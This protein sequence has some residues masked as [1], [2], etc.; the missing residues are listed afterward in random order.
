[1]PN[2]G[3]PPNPPPG[4]SQGDDKMFT[5]AQLNDIVTKRLT[6]DRKRRSAENL[7]DEER[8]GLLNKIEGLETA[9]TAL[10][11]ELTTVKT[12]LDTEKKISEKAH[13]AFKAELVNRAIGESASKAGAVDNSVVFQLLE[14]RTRVREVTEDG[15]PTGK[16][17]T[18]VKV[19]QLVD[20]KEQS[21]WVTPDEGVKSLLEKSPFLVKSQTPAGAG[22]PP[23][24]QPPAKPPG[25]L[26]TGVVKS[27]LPNVGH[28]PKGGG[29]SGSVSDAFS[30]AG[31][32]F[33]QRL[34]QS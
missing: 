4:G 13:R 10:K 21:N 9:N 32:L 19:S 8:T 27:D 16:Y 34:A 3:A 23:A 6:E 14:G 17:V 28:L 7:S 30:K 26:P 1:M 12:G 22:T 5:Q 24:G 25:T 2:E 31:D 11:T 18:E 29:S 20:G 15:Q 33:Q